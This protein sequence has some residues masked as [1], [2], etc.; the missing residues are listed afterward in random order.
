[1][2]E[3]VTI[4]V[5]PAPG[6]G[7]HGRLYLSSGDIVIQVEETIFKIHRHFLVEHSTIL[8]DMF[9]LPQMKSD[10]GTDENPL[11]MPGDTALGWELLL[12][13]FYRENPFLP[14]RYT[15]DQYFAMF[16]VAHKYCMETIQAEIISHLEE[17]KT[18]GDWINLMLASQLINSE[19]LYDDALQGLIQSEP[20]PTLEQA[21]RIGFDAMYAIFSGIIRN[22]P[23][24]S[25]NRFR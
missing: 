20:Q 2:S 18:T 24:G 4:Y 5:R 16:H 13:L 7:R 1:M 23:R 25:R 6:P 12:E 19:R 9:T 10:E 11:T 17:A 14:V 8:R 22:N 15:G 21:K 3:C